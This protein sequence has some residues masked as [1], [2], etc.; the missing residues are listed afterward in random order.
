MNMTLYR[1]PFPS[2]LRDIFGEDPFSGLGLD[3]PRC[4]APSVDVYEKEGVL[5]LEF[6]LPG[7]QKNDISVEFNEGILSVGGDRRFREEGEGIKFYSQERAT[8]KFT[9]SFRIGEGFD[10]KTISASFKDG[11]LYVTISKKE[12]SKPVS[13]KIS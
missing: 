7:L 6:E 8:G 11:I 2:V 3:S 12:E 13:I 9:R 1:R 4:W 5:H 10:P